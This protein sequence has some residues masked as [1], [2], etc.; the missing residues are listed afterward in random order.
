MVSYY[1]PTVRIAIGSVPRVG[2]TS[3]GIVP[4]E[5]G[6]DHAEAAAGLLESDGG[7][8]G[9][10]GGGEVAAGQHEEGDVEG[11]E[12]H[13][14]HDGRPQ[15]AQ[16][17]EE[18]EDEPA[19]QEEAEHRVLVGRD[20]VVAEHVEPGCQDDGVRDPEAA[21]RGER[22]GAE[23]VADGHFPLF[24]VIESATS[25]RG[26]ELLVERRK[27]RRF[28]RARVCGSRKLTT[29]RLAAARDRHSRRP[30]TKR[31]WGG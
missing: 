12:Q 18:G 6:S 25:V 9:A 30:E 17:Q 4:G 2:N 27:R 26:K 19:R 5:E 24:R 22:R 7:L 10:V 29:C 16:Q 28:V 21:V 23:R 13:A 11:E 8:G 3:E 1:N 15:G 20:R 31:C 14:E